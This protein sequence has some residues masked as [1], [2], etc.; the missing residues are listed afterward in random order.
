MDAKDYKDL[1]NLKS[2]KDFAE[3]PVTKA[4]TMHE[5]KTQNLCHLISKSAQK[6]M[7]S[8][9]ISAFLPT[10]ILCRN[11]PNSVSGPK[12]S[13]MCPSGQNQH[14]MVVYVNPFFLAFLFQL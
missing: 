11:T 12:N 3:P 6:R 13:M 4:Y 14:L 9:Q 2:F 7:T 10:H 8:G 5:L 1:I